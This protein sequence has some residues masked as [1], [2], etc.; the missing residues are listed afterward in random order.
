M[1][2]NFNKKH[3]SQSSELKIE[4]N[5]IVTTF[6]LVPDQI[7]MMLDNIPNNASVSLKIIACKNYELDLQPFFFAFDKLQSHIVITVISVIVYQLL[8]SC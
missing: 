4:R 8:V 6:S 3:E 1:L 5:V 2:L 7:N